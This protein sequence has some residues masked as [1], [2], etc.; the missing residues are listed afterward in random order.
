MWSVVPVET[1]VAPVAGD[2]GV[3]VY[4]CVFVTRDEVVQVGR[5]GEKTHGEDTCVHIGLGSFEAG[6]NTQESGRLRA[7]PDVIPVENLH[8]EGVGLRVAFHYDALRPLAEGY[9]T[10]IANLG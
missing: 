5:V 9:A 1:D 10:V 6:H 7:R 4:Q 3:L 8:K 2:V